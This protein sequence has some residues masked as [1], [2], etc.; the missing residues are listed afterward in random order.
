MFFSAA[1]F[2]FF[3]PQRGC[4]VNLSPTPTLNS[5]QCHLL[6]EAT[7]IRCFLQGIGQQWIPAY[8]IL[9]SSKHLM[10]HPPVPHLCFLPLQL[11]YGVLFMT[12]FFP[13]TMKDP[14]WQVIFLAQF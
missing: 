5:N 2:L 14:S 11:Y 8:A 10:S 1:Y 12:Q 7:T 13:P 3:I 4:T 9:C 6:P